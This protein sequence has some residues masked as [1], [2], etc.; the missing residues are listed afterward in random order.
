MRHEWIDS[1]EGH[2]VITDIKSMT[3]GCK[4]PSRHV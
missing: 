4:G 3:A 2:D 1:R